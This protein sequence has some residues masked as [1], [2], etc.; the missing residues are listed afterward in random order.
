[1][2]DVRLIQEVKGA[3]EGLH[4]QGKVIFVAREARQNFAI[5][6]GYDYSPGAGVRVAI[7][8]E[9]CVSNFG[10]R[11]A[12]SV[13]RKISAEKTAGTVHH[14]A[15]RTSGF[16]KEERLASFRVAGEG[17]GRADAF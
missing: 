5:P 2:E 17:G 9:N 4:L 3:V 6:E 7:D 1:M 11:L 16:S 8:V 10:G 15:S 13:V 14:V 12:G